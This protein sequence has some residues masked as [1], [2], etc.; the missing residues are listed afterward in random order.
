[1]ANQKDDVLLK[2]SAEINKDKIG[3]QLNDIADK[4]AISLTNSLSSA[5]SS[6]AKKLGQSI[7]VSFD[8]TIIGT[9]KKPIK[10]TL[11]TKT[12]AKQIEDLVAPLQKIVGEVKTKSSSVKTSTTSTATG[13]RKEIT[14]RR[15]NLNTKLLAT[16]NALQVSD[17]DQ[18][19]INK[20]K[21]VQ[22]LREEIEKM[23]AA[24]RSIKLIKG[25]E[26]IL[27]YKT[28]DIKLIDESE[29]KLESL[30]QKYLQ[31]VNTFDAAKTISGKGSVSIDKQFTGLFD[32]GNVFNT[33]L[34]KSPTLTKSVDKIKGG[35]NSLKESLNLL[36]DELK[37]DEPNL[38]RIEALLK[39]ISQQEALAQSRIKTVNIDRDDLATTVQN[40]ENIARF[41]LLRGLEAEE[42]KA[43]IQFEKVRDK[44]NKNFS[45]RIKEEEEENKK[46]IKFNQTLLKDE[47]ESL[48][49]QIENNEKELESKRK[50]NREA[51]KIDDQKLAKQIQNAQK[52]NT[53]RS[54]FNEQLDKEE[55]ILKSGELESLRS[56]ITLGKYN[57]LLQ[58]TTTSLQKYNLTQKQQDVALKP[59][60][61]NINK[62][63]D[64]FGELNVELNKADPNL[65]TVTR[66][67]NNLEQSQNKISA[68]SNN[69]VNNTSGIIQSI[70]SQNKPSTSSQNQKTDAQKI[71]EINTLRNDVGVSYFDQINK[72]LI[73]QRDLVVK[74]GKVPLSNVIKA[75]REYDS[76]IVRLTKELAFLNEQYDK[77]NINLD[78]ASTKY[79]KIK[80]DLRKLEIGINQIDSDRINNLFNLEENDNFEKKLGYKLGILAFTFQTI[81]GTLSNFARNTFQVF[82]QLAQAAEPIERVTNSLALQVRQG[83][84]SA[85]QQE[86][87]LQRLRD[88]GDIPG[89][90]VEKANETYN[91][92]EKVNISLRERLDLTEGIAK[93]AASP[94][95]TTDSA[96]Q[97]GDV[98][99]AISLE[100]S[101]DEDRFKTL[102][103]SGGTAISGLIE[104]LNFSGGKD[105]ENF[106]IDKFISRVADSLS[107]LESPAATTTDRMN[108]LKSR[109]S[110]L[111]VTLGNIVAPGLDNLNNLLK[112]IQST[113]DNLNT[114]F[115]SLSPNTRNFVGTLLVSLPVIATL[116]GG[117]LTAVAGLGFALSGIR[118]IKELAPAFAGLL[119]TTKT[120]GSLKV[121][122]SGVL[123]VLKDI[124][125]WFKSIGQGGVTVFTALTKG[126][127][128]LSAIFET[129]LLGIASGFAKILGFTNPVVLAINV[130]LSIFTALFDNFNGIRDRLTTV[131]S[132][133]NTSLNKVLKELGLGEIGILGLLDKIF[134]FLNK[135]FGFIGEV[136]L[137]AIVAVASTIRDMLDNISNILKALKSGEWGVALK[138]I[139]SLFFNAFVGVIKNLAIELVATLG[140]AVASLLESSVGEG[141]ASSA[142]RGGANS[143][144]QLNKTDAQSVFDANQEAKRKELVEKQKSDD[145][146]RAKRVKELLADLAAQSDKAKDDFIKFK[147]EQEIE[148]LKTN[149]DAI[150][151]STDLQVES[152]K[153]L[154]EQTEDLTLLSE[155]YSTVLKGLQINQKNLIENQNKIGLTQSLKDFQSLTDSAQVGFDNIYKG[156]ALGNFSF[157]ALV[158][159]IKEAGNSE[160]LQGL[161]Q[162]L[163]QIQTLAKGT[164]AEVFVNNAVEKSRIAIEKNVR[165]LEKLNVQES[166][167]LRELTKYNNERKATLLIESNNR[168]LEARNRERDLETRIRGIN[169]DSNSER[170]K[171]DGGLVQQQEFVLGTKEDSQKRLDEL[172]KQIDE[173]NTQIKN[174]IITGRGKLFQAIENLPNIDPF[175]LNK[176]GLNNK[177][178]L[179]KINT[180]DKFVEEIL[181]STKQINLNDQTVSSLDELKSKLVDV[182]KEYDQITKASRTNNFEKSLTFQKNSIESLVDSF[183][184]L[185]SF[186]TVGLEKLNNIFGKLF[187]YASPNNKDSASSFIYLADSFNY[188]IEKTKDIPELSPLTTEFQKLIETVQTV[189]DINPAIEKFILLSA[190]L[191]SIETINNTDQIRRELNKDLSIYNEKFKNAGTPDISTVKKGDSVSLGN[192]FNNLTGSLGNASNLRDKLTDIFNSGGFSAIYQDEFDKIFNNTVGKSSEDINKEVVKLLFKISNED[193]KEAI[194]IFNKLFNKDGNDSIRGSARA[195]ILIKAFQL[196]TAELKEQNE[197]ERNILESRLNI[198]DLT[199][200]RI[201]QSTESDI[202]KEEQKLLLVQQKIREGGNNIELTNLSKQSAQIKAKLIDLNFEKADIEEAYNIQKAAIQAN[203]DKGEIERIEDQ[204]KIRRQALLDQRNQDIRQLAQEGYLSTDKDGNIVDGNGKILLPKKAQVNN[205]P[206]ETVSGTV[207]NNT[208]AKG[209]GETLNQSERILASTRV[210][211]DQIDGIV[212]GVKTLEGTALDAGNAM[213]SLFDRFKSGEGIINQ[214]K[215]LLGGL[216]F[217]LKELGKTFTELAKFGITAFSDALGAAIADTIVN[218]G[219]FLKNLGKFFGD[220]LIALG[221]QLVQLGIAAL[222]MAALAAAFPPLKPALNPD[223]D[224]FV[225]GALATAVGIGLILAGKAL[226]GGGG[227]TAAEE[228][229]QESSSNSSNTA[230]G[231]DIVEYDPEKDPLVLYQKALAARVLIEVRTDDT[232][233]V[234]KFIKLN[235]RNERFGNITGNNRLGIP[236]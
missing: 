215:R 55:G 107:K 1:M 96:K 209:N 117:L 181:N 180:D 165:D 139:A 159:T 213:L 126:F 232:N 86:V 36:N 9:L 226:G 33:F 191:S 158:N 37:E 34:S 71:L 47:D 58:T 12:A 40:D 207:T 183:S 7:Q 217:S 83:K 198:I 13:T 115:K 32:S 214:F 106:G 231:N 92:L 28:S 154:A 166:N 192:I 30:R 184:S 221:T 203:G 10:L 49:K 70:V 216:K 133:L 211:N 195:D 170:L 219:N 3:K 75:T 171:R 17:N 73:Q 134:Q 79:R 44:K 97:F 82:D 39:R 122:L 199:S 140:D 42:E 206:G 72:E 18:D 220:M 204:G 110:E 236:I 62:L 64:I 137:D 113:I 148:K 144:R 35:I 2:F 29:K 172:K 45:E 69:L 114:S 4:I 98:I 174:Y 76:A 118:Q 66:L 167:R 150:K 210:A 56:T 85:D 152:F 65:K 108:R 61:T 112:S 77:G 194:N 229:V 235:N 22:S 201:I 81:G 142:F 149:I 200:N 67:L 155:G 205:L 141:R 78:E 52:E 227:S 93:L 175:G 132:Q 51:D 15:R 46:R 121:S 187:S 146:D 11:D 178:L 182:N 19:N 223:G 59:I 14:D 103:R 101:V 168:K 143:L 222:A 138:E 31:I 63:Q 169:N 87:I 196:Y 120:L 54:K 136:L 228:S 94:G 88:I 190:K 123:F 135:I 197:I 27:P 163:K 100:G 57:T 225:V 161:E 202:Q 130:I 176:F 68:R 26:D 16:E 90:S 111:G 119:N 48:K 160:N 129:G 20:I 38:K 99:A 43:Q 173:L 230:N 145:V 186:S 208:I 153:T 156:A 177:Q 128:G 179:E 84:I 89:S 105:I 164:T 218:G 124:S 21:A 131:F 147:A 8:D 25:G 162:K 91:A 189:E 80:D 193:R 212:D 41:K 60:V 185:S 6:F 233:I 125:F 116:F 157:Q 127:A 234:K 5:T 109:M 24:L 74:A 23:S 188:L 104:S 95:G 53:V 151:E 224:G 102:R 50:F